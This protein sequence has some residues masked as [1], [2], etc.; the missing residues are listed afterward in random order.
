MLVSRAVPG[1]K[2]A[3]VIGIDAVAETVRAAERAQ[4][5]HRSITVQK[6]AVLHVPRSV[7]PARHLTAGVDARAATEQAA[8][9][10]QIPH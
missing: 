8:E 1:P 9:R 6:R 4:I 5:P 7:G 3:S 10:A 2:V